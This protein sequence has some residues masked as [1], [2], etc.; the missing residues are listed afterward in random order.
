[1]ILKD[2]EEFEGYDGYEGYDPCDAH[3]KCLSLEFLKI[4]QKGVVVCNNIIQY[5]S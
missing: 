4:F 5:E 3:V 2:F 1:M